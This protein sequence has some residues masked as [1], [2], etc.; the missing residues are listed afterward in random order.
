MAIRPE[1]RKRYPPDW[2]D[3]WEPLAGF[4]SADEARAIDTLRKTLGV[5]PTRSFQFFEA[6]VARILDGRLTSHK[7]GWD[8]EIGEG[9]LVIRI[10]V[11]YAAESMCRFRNGPRP[12]FKFADPRGRGAPK[13]AHA[14]VLLGIDSAGDLHAWVAPRAGV[15]QVPS[16]TLTAPKH[17]TG[18]STRAFPFDAFRCPPSQ[19]LPEVLRAARDLTV[20]DAKHH[21]ETAA[22][23]RRARAN[24]LEMF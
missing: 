10:E 23:T 17:R 16:I 3:L 9:D 21:A 20:Y 24:T 5:D 19:L 14:L 13:D 1:N 22:A 8:V 4:L 12:I 11:K 15:G 7:C 2:P 6:L 18:T